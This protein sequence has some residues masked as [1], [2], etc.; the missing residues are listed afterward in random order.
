MWKHYVQ[1]FDSDA[2]LSAKL[3]EFAA[4]VL[5]GDGSVI[6]IATRSRLRCLKALLDED[7]PCKEG[8]ASN[9]GRLV[10]LDAHDILARFMVDGVPDESRFTSVIGNL[11]AQASDSG[12]RRV[13]IC[14]EMVTLLCAAGHRDAALVIEQLW[15][16][17]SRQHAFDLLCA[18][19]MSA[20][21]DHE[22][23]GAFDAVCKSHSR[24]D[25][26]ECVAETGADTDRLHRLVTRLQ[27]RAN[28]FE[29]ELGLRCRSDRLA[30]Q[31][32]SR[33]SA[34][35]CSNAALKALAG[36]DPLTGLGNRRTFVDGLSHAF[37]RAKRTRQRVALLFVD[38]DDFKRFNDR[39]G[40]QMGDRL[41][42]EVAVRLA[43]CI[44]ASEAVY[45]LGGDEFAVVMEDADVQAAA[46]LAERILEAF[47]NPFTGDASSVGVTASI[48]I[49]LYPDDASTLETLVLKADQAMYRVKALGKSGYADTQ[50]S[51]VACGS[52]SFLTQG[53]GEEINAASSK[54]EGETT[55]MTV[56]AAA[57]RLELS[58]PHIVKLI[59]ERRFG[60]V[61]PQ[62]GTWP[63]LAVEEVSRVAREI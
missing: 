2:F 3:F 47:S 48:G 44:R 63:L 20:F 55:W 60:K 24:I 18:Y 33:I 22:H 49:G 4:T 39:L 57:A 62:D 31:L 11:V 15:E 7:E 14:G 58:R 45:R 23:R 53:Q 29:H 36:H 37:A 40:H 8:R 19:P 59:T 56:E 46:L 13:A 6:I 10:C 26:P 16:T 17:L 43:G 30:K 32:A 27:Q 28:S 12:S 25:A 50:T 34:L 38:L 41:L 42:R 35:E 9:S 5:R 54:V 1:F 61:L 21:P 52:V 51:P